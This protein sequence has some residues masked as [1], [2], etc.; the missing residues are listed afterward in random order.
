MYVLRFSIAP[1]TYQ[2]HEMVEALP[3]YVQGE[4]AVIIALGK[5][6]SMSREID[7]NAHNAKPIRLEGLPQRIM[8]TQQIHDVSPMWFQFL[9]RAWRDM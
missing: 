6:I 5:H 1:V 8:S 3:C 4:S 2:R 9:V 7:V